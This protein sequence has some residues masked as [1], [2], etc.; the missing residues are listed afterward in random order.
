MTLPP[1]TLVRSRRRK[2]SAVTLPTAPGKFDEPRWKSLTRYFDSE[3]LEG[4]LGR[5]PVSAKT[6]G[7]WDLGAW[8]GGLPD[9]IQVMNQAQERVMFFEVQSAI[10]SSIVSNKRRVIEWA[11][12]QLK[13]PQTAREKRE[14]TDAVIDLDFFALAEPVRK[15]VGVHYLIGVT[16]DAIAGEVDD[17]EGHVVHSDFYCSVDTKTSL[18]ST[19]GLREYAEQA[20]RTFEFAVAFVIVSV[21][22]STLNT[23]I[24]YHENKNCLMDY[25]YDRSNITGRLAEPAICADCAKASRPK[26]LKTA[27]ILLGQLSQYPRPKRLPKAS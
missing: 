22:F 12:Q 25:N 18:V 21:V 4:T 16:P 2:K 6:F 1:Y 14:Q 11:E 27:Q 17:E 8:V 20:N 26:V 5:T 24:G 23:K 19:A 15:D 3:S 7:I 9:V 13:R 10:P